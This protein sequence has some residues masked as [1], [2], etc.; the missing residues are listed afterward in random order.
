MRCVTAALRSCLHYASRP[1]IS[2]SFR[3]ISSL[4]MAHTTE[5]PTDIEQQGGFDFT[6]GSMGEEGS[7]SPRS[8][9][10]F[11][12]QIGEQYRHAGPQRW[13][14]QKTVEYPLFAES[15]SYSHSCLS[16]LSHEFLI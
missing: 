9:K 2:P 6:S 4:P 15:S 12:E 11:M 3:M 1:T 16:A 7:A 14:G 5:T 10:Q 13:L 8:Y